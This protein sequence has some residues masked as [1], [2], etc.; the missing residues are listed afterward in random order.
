ML[1]SYLPYIGFVDGASHSSQNLAFVAWAIYA[2]TNELI[3]LQGFAS[4]VQPIILQN[5]MQPLNY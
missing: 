3:S 5:I 4:V 1:T 2:P